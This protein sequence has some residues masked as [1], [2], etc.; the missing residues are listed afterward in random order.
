M[1]RMLQ[2][3]SALPDNIDTLKSLLVDQVAQRES[4]AYTNTQLLAENQYIKAQVLLLQE[5]LNIALAQRYAARSEQYSPDQIRLFNEAEADPDAPETDHPSVPDHV[6]IAA[7]T[8]QKRG[9]QPLPDHLPRIEVIHD[10]PE[11]ERYCDHDGA[12]L[13]AMGTVIS[14]QLDIVPATIR[15]I[16]HIRRQYACDCGQCIKTATLPAQPIPKSL[17]APGLLAHVVV[18]K[19]VD[20]LP[21]YRQER[22]LQRIGVDI[23]RKSVV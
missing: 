5:R 21:L 16:R 8:R 22:I 6:I 19:Y 20:A 2:R 12:P 14:E 7:H 11:T 1:R 18:C 15:V 23:D 3:D 4:L 10:L 17:A 9:R 13:T